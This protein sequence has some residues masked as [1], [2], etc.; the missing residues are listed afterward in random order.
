VA[1][2]L[3]LVETAVLGS[4]AAV[5][6]DG[7]VH[8]VRRLGKG[9]ASGLVNAVL[10]RAVDAWNRLEEN[11]PPDVLWSHPGWMY[12]RWCTAFGEDAAREIVRAN[13]RPASVWVWWVRDAE[14]GGGAAPSLHVVEPHPWCPGAWRAPGD[15]A[16]MAAEAAAG[17]AYVQDPASQLVA[18]LAVALAGKGSLLDLCAAPGGKAVL[19]A[20]LG[21]WSEVIACDLSARRLALV[22]R[23]ARLAGVEV[24]GVVADATR[25]AIRQGRAGLVALDAPCSGTGTLRRHPELRWRLDPGAIPERAGVQRRMIGAALGAVA[26]GGVLLYT[27]CSLEPEENEE[28]FEEVPPGFEIVDLVP[29]LPPGVPV[30]GTPAGGLRLYPADHWDGFGL[31]ALR[32]VRWS[33]AT[34]SR[35][36]ITDGDTGS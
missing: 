15:D 31:H 24:D 30:V 9:S 4:P 5:A 33:G 26:P 36:A 29:F 28:H 25:P 21:G 17:R 10:R 34:T 2:R 12:R 18:H 8:L 16:L 22:R 23:L 7:A 13:Q 27:T 3:G 6:V 32:R 1:L 19:A 14:D 35:N 11:A 20:R